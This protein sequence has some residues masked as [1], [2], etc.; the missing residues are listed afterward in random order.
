MA[1]GDH[2]WVKRRGYTHHGIDAG[3][4]TVLH[5]AGY[6]WQRNVTA[7]VER[8]TW[9]KF[10]KGAPVNVC[11]VSGDV[12]RDAVVQRAE[13]RLGEQKYNLITNNCEH[14]ARWCVEGEERSTQVATVGVCTVLLGVGALCWW[15]KRLD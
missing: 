8:T 3:D 9:D 11:E 2:L 13:S 1:K 10:A 14:F 12:N 15:Y 7:K 4:G 5:Y 6:P